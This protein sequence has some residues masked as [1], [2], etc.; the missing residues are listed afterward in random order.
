MLFLSTR[1]ADTRRS[2]GLWSIPSLPDVPEKLHG[3]PVVIVAGVF[4]GAPQQSDPVLGPLQE[5]ATPLAD[6]SG[7]MPYVD[8]QSALG[9]L[10]PHGGRY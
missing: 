7:T 10:F 3:A 4:N 8:S 1:V 2:L 5:L 6:M 9:E